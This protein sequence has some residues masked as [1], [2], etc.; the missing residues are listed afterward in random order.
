M[1]DVTITGETT[2]LNTLLD[3]ADERERQDQKWGSQRHLQA[4]TWF[5]ILGEEVGEVARALLDKE[6][7]ARLK[8]EL[9][10][11]AAVAVAWAETLET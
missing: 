7:D 4:G 10:Q 5:L 8:A 6:G 3:V 2:L 9:I 11:V 1:P